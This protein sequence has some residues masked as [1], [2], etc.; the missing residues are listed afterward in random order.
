MLL[1]VADFR[2]R[3]DRDLDGLISHLSALT[4]RSGEEERQAWRN[5]LPALAN[6]LAVPMLQLFHLQLGQGGGG[7]AVEY[8]LPGSGSWCD[9]VLLGRGPARP[10][11]VI[12]ELKD[13]ETAGDRPGPSESLIWHQEKQV[14]HPSDQV[15]GYAEYAEHYHSAVQAANAT[16]G[17]CVFFTR[18]WEA[19]EYAE[20]PHDQL[21]ARYPIFCFSPDDRETNLPDFLARYLVRPDPEFARAFEAGTY[22]QDRNF[23]ESVARAMLD[24]T[25]PQLVLL[26]EQRRGLA[27]CHFEVA[28]TLAKAGPGQKSVVIVQGPPGSGK[29]AVA[30]RLWAELVR[31]S[32]IPGNVVFATTSGCQRSN[33]EQLFQAAGRRKGA[34]GIVWPV[35]RFN[36]GLTSTWVKSQQRLGLSTAV[37]DWK[38]HLEANLARGVGSR[39]PDNLHDVTIVDEAHSLI[40]P[41]KPGTEGAPPSG[42]VFHAGPQAWHVIRGSRVSV[43]FMDGG[44]SYRDNET[45]TVEDIRRWAAEFGAEVTEVSLAGAQFRCA[46]S[47]GYVDWVDGLL[48]LRDGPAPTTW[49][50]GSGSGPFLFE[51]AEDP[52]GLDDFLR[53]RLRGTS[54]GRLVASYGRP[55]VTKHV[56]VPHEAPPDTK[57]FCIQAASKPPRTWSRVWNHAPEG[58][59]TRFIQAPPG[60]SMHDDPLCEVGCPYVVRGFDFDYVGLLWLSDLVWR[61]DRWVAQ[62]AHVHESAWPKTKARARRAAKAGRQ[63]EEL[64]ARLARGY[65]ILLTRALRG[66]RVWFEDSETREHVESALQGAP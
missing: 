9:A 39:V 50:A 44:Q 46:G 40:D 37:A 41:T 35:N 28:R 10:S 26:D 51:I 11:A 47:R 61:G 4:E 5:S 52:F 56:A 60:T 49:R 59:Y 21:V 6:V 43:F 8:R 2:R 18:A 31:E 30:A 48:G 24:S 58:D 53:S 33:W 1:E 25:L 23:V 54:T 29:S 32:G 7:V 20:P 22:R 64:V 36:P 63:S 16:V 17:G 55:W 34:A 12:V 42:W 38:R 14:L 62:L 57:D 65:R 19:N 13:W 27:L 45:T 3:V 66:I 15:K